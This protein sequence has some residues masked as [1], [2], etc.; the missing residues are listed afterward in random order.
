MANPNYQRGAAL[1]RRLVADLR[2]NGCAAW[3]VAGSKGA[4]DVIAAC[5]DG[6]RLY[7]CKTGNGG[8]FAGF[9]PKE[10]NAL[11]TEAKL[12]GGVAWYCRGR[13]GGY[14]LIPEGAWPD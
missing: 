7:Q 5:P 11:R 6:L 12:A 1:E 4:A 3:R 14:D 8:P 2:E 13:R 10:R 9:P